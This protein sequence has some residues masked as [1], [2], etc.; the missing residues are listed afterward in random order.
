MKVVVYAVDVGSIPR[1]RLGWARADFPGGQVNPDA[2]ENV[3][4]ARRPSAWLGD[5]A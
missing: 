2:Q 4:L 3:A 5:G 1:K